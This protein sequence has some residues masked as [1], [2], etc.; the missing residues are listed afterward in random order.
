MQCLLCMADDVGGIVCDARGQQHAMCGACAGRYLNETVIPNGVPGAWEHI[1]CPAHTN[2]C[3][4]VLSIEQLLSG[5]DEATRSTAMQKI[6]RKSTGSI[7]NMVQCRRCKEFYE[8]PSDAVADCLRC[9]A[10]GERGELVPLYVEPPRSAADEKSE[11][12][13]RKM[14]TK[15][16]NPDCG[17]NISR[18]A[19]CNHMTCSR[20]SKEFCYVCGQDWGSCGGYFKCNNSRQ[21][22]DARARDR[23]RDR[24]RREETEEQRDRR[25]EQDLNPRCEYCAT[26]GIRH[27][28]HVEMRPRR[29]SCAPTCPR[30]CTCEYSRWVRA[31]LHWR[32]RPGAEP[33]GY[34]REAKER[35]DTAYA[36]VEE[37]ARTAICRVCGMRGHNFGNRGRFCPLVS[38]VEAADALPGAASGDAPGDRAGPSN[39]PHAAPGGSD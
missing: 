11:A 4:G 23:A 7:S 28:R 8:R 19:G 6:A 24:R 30:E 39:R 26:R 18:T 27:C 15:C 31:W 37:R 20:C 14:S 1:R 17:A 34:G 5:V 22:A 21:Q 12:A 36:V 33:E 16:P 35:L 29:P 10:E 2:G 25:L 13:V 3:Q 32:P 38:L 9:R